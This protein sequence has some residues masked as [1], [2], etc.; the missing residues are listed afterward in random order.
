MKENLL[1]RLEGRESLETN[2]Q[3]EKIEYSKANLQEH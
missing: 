3:A 1:S 2:I